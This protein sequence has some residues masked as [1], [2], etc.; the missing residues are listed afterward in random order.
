MAQVSLP[1]SRALFE[2]DNIKDRISNRK[3]E[4]IG[5]YP[6]LEDTLKTSFQVLYC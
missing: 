5:G 3:I 1:S 2:P 4:N 6:G